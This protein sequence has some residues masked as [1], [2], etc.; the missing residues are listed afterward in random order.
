M[1]AQ[2]SQFAVKLLPSLAD[3]AFLMPIVFLFGRMDGLKTLLGDCDTGW[4]IRTGEW[5][6][7]HGWVPARDIFSF[8]KPGGPWFAWE[9]LSDVLFAKLNAAGGLQAVALF[10]ILL[11]CVTF[12]VLFLVVKRKA[13]A[14]VSIAITML[15]AAASSIHWL[16]RPHLFTLLFLVLFY[17]ALEQVREG[18]TRIAGVPYLAILP[19]ATIL[20]TNLHAGFFAGALMIAAFGAGELLTMAFSANPA[21]RLPAW[22]NARRYFLSALACM[23]AS[24]I[25]PYTYHL[26]AHMAQYLR[27]PFNSQYIMEFLSPNFHHPAAIFFEVMLVLAVATAVWGVSQGRFAGP[28]L[29][30]VWAHGGLLAA[31]NIPIFVIAAAPP[32]GEAIQEWLL[33]LP[34]IQAAEWLRK[35]G[36]K[37]NRVAAE[38]G[39]TD[40]MGRWH[41][42]SVAGLAL[43]AALLYAPHP[44]KKFRAEFD[45]DS[46]PAGALA[47]LR[48]I[49]AA[50]IF[51][52]D[53]WGD[54]LI[55]TGHKV[56][57]DGR[58]DYYGDDF[59]EKCIDVLSV[60][61]G[62]EKTLNQFGIDTILMPPSAPLSGALK[63]SRNWRVVYDD[64]ISL[65]FR[66]ASRDREAA[67]TQTRDLPGARG[68]VTK[69]GAVS[70]VITSG[71]NGERA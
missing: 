28:L 50:R 62:W 29:I 12:T 63:E 27:D 9:W 66:P 35:A 41:L 69:I 6:L 56:F 18:R 70:S 61:Y 23:A 39:E 3:F 14:I 65:V 49:P 55:W 19:V 16:A 58:S 10:S 36:R 11:L 5:I 8:S 15:A 32:V 54:Y 71:R 42:V 52:F 34:G 47:T 60:K 26:H 21:G 1:Q 22:R 17:A 51:T 30:L 2:R 45:P 31:R 24:L 4:H 37:F 13:N 33:L 7:A 44:P 40:A 57:V 64:G 20:W 68:S 25:N 59:E 43:V 53:Q 46:H 38:T 48:R 67:K